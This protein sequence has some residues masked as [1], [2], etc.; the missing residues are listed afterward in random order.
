VSAPEI[1]HRYDVIIAGAR[2][3]G[4][5]TA[6]LLARKGASVLMVDPLPRG[7]DTLSTHALMRGA[8][9]QLHRW[10]LLES[11]RASGTPAVRATTFHYGDERITVPIKEKDGVDALYAP[12]RTVLDPILVEA[13]EAAGAE[14]V[15]GVA[16][17]DLLRDD[18]GRV[19]GA[20]IE[21]AGMPTRH[22]AA[23]MVIGA[24]GVRSRVARMA[25]AQLEYSMP[26]AAASI[27]GH[28]PG[29]SVEGYHWHFSPGVGSGAIP[30]NDGHT[31]VFAG[32]S[33]REFQEGRSEGLLPLYLRALRQSAPELADAVAGVRESV[34]LRAFAG[35]PGFLRRSTGPGW[36]LVGD[37]GFFRDPLTA[38]GITDAF[39]DAELLVRAISEGSEEALER[40]RTVRAEVTRGLMDVT[41][42]IASLEWD[43]DEVQALHLTLNREMNVGL[44][45]IRTYGAGKDRSPGI[46][47]TAAA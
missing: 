23:A 24:D 4:A 45:L 25:G 36:A 32:I 5:A 37:A 38:H 35:V 15:H 33:Q 30:T 44:D 14:V 12:R 2:C 19:T 13:A 46:A 16:V 40:Y 28:W 17:V 47:S 43:M 42:R 20:A 3:A 11:V 9:F 41:D 29:L 7:R 26:H 6:M 34:K 18:D 39:R 27:Y 8:V 22:V 10:D 31:C 21:G 1:R